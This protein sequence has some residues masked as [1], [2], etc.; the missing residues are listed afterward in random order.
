MIM[1]PSYFLKALEIS[2]LACPVFQKAKLAQWI[3]EKKG[4]PKT[5]M[6]HIFLKLIKSRYT[7][8]KKKAKSEVSLQ[9]CEAVR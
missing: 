8:K 6:F 3:V 2:C 1:N 5:G 7:G 9:Y 4:Y